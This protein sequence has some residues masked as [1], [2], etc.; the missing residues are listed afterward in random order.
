LPCRRF[1]ERIAER[2]DER[3]DARADVLKVDHQNVACVHHRGRR[4]AD[5]AV[6][7]EDRHAV[8]RIG[9]V[10]RLD[11]VVLLVAAQPVLRPEGRGEA[12]VAG[13]GERVER[14][15]ELARDRGRVGDQT[16]APAGE[17]LSERGI[18]EQ[19]VDAEAHGAD[20]YHR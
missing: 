18:F 19:A 15:H 14:M 6:E 8:L 5:R 12:D 1:L 7:T 4:P 3:V 9:E 16:D 13:G 2:G 17:A 20:A 11:H 10:G